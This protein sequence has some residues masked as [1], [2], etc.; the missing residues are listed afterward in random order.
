MENKILNGKAQ[1]LGNNILG[2]S[3]NSMM[4]EIMSTAA[5]ILHD[6]NT[7]E[8]NINNLPEYREKQT[9]CGKFLIDSVINSIHKTIELMESDKS[10]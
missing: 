8:V 5:V 7:G 3:F 1:R 6:V 9:D 4:N 2:H 10:P